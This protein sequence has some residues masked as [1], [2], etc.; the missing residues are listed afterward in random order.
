ML[1]QNNVVR[2]IR[3]G[4][5]RLLV[6]PDPLDLVGIAGDRGEPPPELL[7][8]LFVRLDHQDP[9]PALAR[10]HAEFSGA[11]VLDHDS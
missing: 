11:L 2:P 10:V 9:A 5:K 7:M 8:V 4:L 3:N 6:R 1:G